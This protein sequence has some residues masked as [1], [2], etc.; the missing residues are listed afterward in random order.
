[1]SGTDAA[2]VGASLSSDDPM[3]SAALI[4]SADGCGGWGR[5]PGSAFDF[6]W[7]GQ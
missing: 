1:V 4:C 5:W 2:P 7:I 6:H 3:V